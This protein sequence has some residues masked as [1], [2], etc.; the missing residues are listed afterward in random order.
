MRIN[1]RFQISD[2]KLKL[3]DVSALL[4]FSCLLF[5][6]VALASGG[7][8][9][10]SLM[11]WVWRFVNFGLLV[12][13]LVKFLNKPL[14]DYFTQRK[15]LIAKSIKESQ[16][17]KELAVKALAE[18]EERLKL[19]DKEVE[20]ILEAAKASGERERQRLIAE[21]E[22]LKAKVLEQAKVNI[23]YE[24]KRAKEI[25]KSEA[26]EAALKL[27]EDKIKNRLSKEDQEK[28]LQ[29]SL[30]MLGKN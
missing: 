26:A 4:F 12:I 29:N 30:K 19:K 20:E 2:F 3:S 16:E 21:G 23:E 10:N 9:G 28:L 18:V 17:A 22:K 15:E 7:G 11:E 1:F 6:A 25:I 8:E 27:A 14:R 5:P 13:I 24:L